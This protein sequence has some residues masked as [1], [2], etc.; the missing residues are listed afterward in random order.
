MEFLISEDGTTS[1]PM[2]D[3]DR[4]T[5]YHEAYQNGLK[6]KAYVKPELCTVVDHVGKTLKE[7]KYKD[8]IVHE[9]DIYCS[10]DRLGSTRKIS[11]EC[12][13]MFLVLGKYN[14]CRQKLM[15]K[16]RKDGEVNTTSHVTMTGV[17]SGYS[18]TSNHI[19]LRLT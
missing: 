6:L 15:N 11:R 18:N 10:G 4:F 17:S 19:V 9:K 8:F 2:E 5:V 12:R 13:N 7:G 14:K 3:I 16:V 1:V